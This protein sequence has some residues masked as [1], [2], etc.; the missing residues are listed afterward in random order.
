MNWKFSLGDVRERAHWDAYMHAY[1]EALTH[2]STPWA[3][4]YVVPADKKWFTRL[5]VGAAITAA[6][7]RVKLRYPRLTA[8]ARAELREAK[9]LL[10]LEPEEAT[11]APRPGDRE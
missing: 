6:L 4:W 1:E 5:V 11:P 2:T 10:E 3:P 9:R 7:G 8:A